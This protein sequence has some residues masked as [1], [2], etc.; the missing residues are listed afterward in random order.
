MAMSKEMFEE[1]CKKLMEVIENSK[2]MVEK[3]MDEF[4][5]E[6]RENQEKTAEVVT[7]VKRTKAPDFKKG[8]EIQFAFNEQVSCSTMLSMGFVACK[9]F[10]Q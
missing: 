4:R 1:Q 10:V 8:N 2:T 9:T 6:M 5:I 7:K 3:K